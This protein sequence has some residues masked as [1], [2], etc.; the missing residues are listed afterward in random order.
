MARAQHVRFA[1]ARQ[2]RGLEHVPEAARHAEVGAIV[3]SD[4]L[5]GLTNELAI[6]PGSVPLR[7]TELR[8][9]PGVASCEIANLESGVG[10][11]ESP[12]KT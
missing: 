9:T 5:G 4:M 8:C 3:T 2:Y 12:M 1:N 10:T 7:Q 6:P 11:R